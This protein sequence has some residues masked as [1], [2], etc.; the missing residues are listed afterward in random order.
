MEDEKI[1][2]LMEGYGAGRLT[3]EEEIAFFQWYGEAS[4]EEFHRI[5][6]HCHFSS[7]SLL[8]SP[9]IPDDLRA[10][11][12][13]AIREHEA[14]EQQASVVP[15][16]RLRWI[17]AAA[18]FLVLSVGGYVIYQSRL[19]HSTDIARLQPAGDVAP[20]MTKAVLTLADGS[21]I[22]LDSVGS[23]QLAVQGKTIVQNDHGTV[24]YSGDGHLSKNEQSPLYNTLAT[25]RGEQSPPLSLADG[26]KVWL[27]ALSSIRF[28]V[29]F[30]GDAREVEISG[31]VFFEVAR[32]SAQP[33]R[34]RT[35]G[36]EVEVLGT[37]FS[38][39]AYSDEQDIRTT[40]LE[41]RVRVMSQEEASRDQGLIL[42]AGQQARVRDGVSLV[43]NAN[44]DQAV[45]W[46]RGL[47]DFNHADLQTVLRQLSRWYDID[48]KFEGNIP[49]RSF[50]GKITRDLSLSQVIHI[51]QDLDVKFRIEGK[52][53]I[54][55]P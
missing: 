1:I 42:E 15:L 44:I 23:G 2:A 55:T 31:E 11:L 51:L 21:R 36:M 38:V 27:N 53:L 3:E 10:A 13:Q 24:S 34:V 43:R 6:S 26:T 4:L 37:Q 48:V 46:K 19:S 41:G 29:A 52:T 40:L 9:E 39:N 50:H 33:F 5:L 7:A 25:G 47:F 49:A 14:Y 12:E 17:W 8:V 20:G 22:V 28:P 16:R 30:S 45:A 18:I 35:K 32:L 54:I